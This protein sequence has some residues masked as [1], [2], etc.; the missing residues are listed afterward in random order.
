[1]VLQLQLNEDPNVVEHIEQQLLFPFLTHLS[2]FHPL[3]LTL[4]WAQ[5]LNGALCDHQRQPLQISSPTSMTLTH[6]LRA[7]HDAILVGIGTVLADDPRLTV[8]LNHP[9][10][11]HQP[12]PIVFDS[13]L[14]LPLSANLWNHPKPPW[15]LTTCQDLAQI[16]IYEQ[17]GAKVCR[18]PSLAKVATL[19][20]F[21]HRSF[22]RLLVEGGIQLLTSFLQASS[23]SSSLITACIITVAP[24][25]VQGPTGGLI[26]SALPS[27]AHVQ[28]YGLGRDGVLVMTQIPF[29][30]E[31]KEKEERD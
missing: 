28:W 20:E 24:M 10:Y 7:S 6:L 13:S 15:I 3:T 25:H 21:L 31:E 23:S 9:N 16:K 22:P 8:R 27:K 29:Q 5:T 11:Q 12:Q 4:T 30:R 2:S 1:M 26:S 17:H 19:V 18:F 14:R